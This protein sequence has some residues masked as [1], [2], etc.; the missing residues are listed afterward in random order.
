MSQ[1]NHWS[2]Q[3]FFFVFFLAAWDMMQ[4]SAAPPQRIAANCQSAI[5]GTKVKT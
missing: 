5:K 4:H 2:D 1:R 3:R